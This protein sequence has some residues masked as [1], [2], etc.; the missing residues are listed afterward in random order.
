MIRKHLGMISRGAFCLSAIGLIEKLST[1]A[2]INKPQI[3]HE[4]TFTY[5]IFSHGFNG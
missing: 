5:C 2:I 4:E 3:R 1:F